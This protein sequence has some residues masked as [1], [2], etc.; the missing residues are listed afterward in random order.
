MLQE[1]DHNIA[2]LHGSSKYVEWPNA[3]V[4]ANV[5]AGV[6]K[7]GGNLLTVDPAPPRALTGGSQGFGRCGIVMSKVP[8]MT[9]QAGNRVSNDHPIVAVS[10]CSLLGHVLL[11]IRGE[12]GKGVWPEMAF[13][14]ADNCCSSLSSVCYCLSACVFLLSI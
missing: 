14:D 5:P 11:S 10:N 4:V 1:E 12:G 9:N 3:Q 8:G 2:G 13:G 7:D 6:V